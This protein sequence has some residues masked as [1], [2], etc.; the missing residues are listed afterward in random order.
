M[1]V[2]V[3]F[4]VPILPLPYSLACLEEERQTP[5][6]RRIRDYYIQPD[7]IDSWSRFPFASVWE[8]VLGELLPTDPGNQFPDLA[9]AQ[10]T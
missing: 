7:D 4:P 9:F 5:E 2:P 3:P 1:T 10:L 6:T 8:Y